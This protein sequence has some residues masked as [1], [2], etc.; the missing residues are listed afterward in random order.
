MHASSTIFTQVKFFV[1]SIVL[2]IGMFFSCNQASDK[3]E[4]S[5]GEFTEQTQ[6][7]KFWIR[8]SSTLQK[9]T[10]SDTSIVRNIHWLQPLSSLNEKIELS[11]S[12]PTNGKSY[13]LYLDESDLNFVDIVYTTNEMNQVNQ[14]VFD[15]Y[16]EDKSETKRLLEEFDDYFTIKHGKKVVEGKV[17]TWVSKSATKIQMEDV[18]TSKDPGIKLIYTLLN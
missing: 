1:F 18:S 5:T 14:V 13:T 16:V 11:E 17:N 8:A 3:K 10:L 6:S 15:I 4:N 2:S 9:I 7:Q 12:Q